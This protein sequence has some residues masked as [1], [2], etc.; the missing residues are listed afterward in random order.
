MEN[1]YGTSYIGKMLGVT[2]ASVSNWIKRHADTPKPFGV[3]KAPSQEHYVWDERGLQE[4]RE[5]YEGRIEARA[6]R[7]AEEIERL[8]ERIARLQARIEAKEA[9]SE[10]RL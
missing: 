5:W 3:V 9:N 6:R 2:N 1:L 10:V 7:E 4:W 8:R